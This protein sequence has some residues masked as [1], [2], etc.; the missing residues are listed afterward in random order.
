MIKK[1]KPRVESFKVEQFTR[2][3]KER[4]KNIKNVQLKV[5]N[6]DDECKKDLESGNG[7]LITN[8][9][10]FNEKTGNR[11][12]DGLYSPLYG[13]DTFTDKLTDDMYKCECGKTVGGIYE[14]DIC[15]YCNTPVVFADAKLSITGYISLGKYCIINPTVYMWLEHAI[16]GK[17]LQS[18]IKFN[19]KFNVNGKNVSTKTKNSP[20]NGIGLIAFREQFDEILD[21]YCNKRKTYEY[22]ELIQKYRDCVFTH[23]V[24]VYSALLRP[25]VKEGS[26]IS[27]FNVNRSYSIILVNANNVRHSDSVI[28][29][30]VIIENSLYEIQTEFNSICTNDIIKNALSSKKGIIRGSLTACRVDY[31]GRFVIAAG[32]GL[33]TTEVNLPYIGG[34]ELMRPLII[35]AL[36]SIEDMNIREANSLVDNAL[37]Q[38]DKK[39]WLI[40]NFILMNSKNP[41]M[42]MVQRSPSLLQESMRLMHI[43]MVKYD[44]DDLTLDVP[45]AILSGMNADYDG[46]TFACNMIYDNRLKEAW[47]AIHSPDCHFISRHNGKYSD[48][49]EFIKDT[50]VTLSE[51]WELGKDSNYF[52][53]WATESERNSEIAK[54]SGC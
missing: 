8:E 11:T 40:M 37:R 15:P 39:I 43:K 23:Y 33:N 32:I 17:E 1:E 35:K 45:T 38:F 12:M 50:A 51:L 5:I 25:L 28:D 26:R 20:Y 36:A 34:C 54:I 24:S 14:G 46:D 2:P 3:F 29:K 16:G 4:H 9:Q 19:N 53:D 18:I 27:Q 30:T 48:H 41:P 21:Y 7:F 42:L 47:S 22:Y 13:A 31:S 6:V 52:A 49:A 44:I 10:D